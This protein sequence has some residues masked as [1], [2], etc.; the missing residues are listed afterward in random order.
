M[1]VSERH[2]SVPGWLSVKRGRLL[3]SAGSPSSP[4]GTAVLSCPPYAQLPR[5]ACELKASKDGPVSRRIVARGP[6]A[7]E[8]GNN[9]GRS[10][11]EARMRP[12]KSIRSCEKEK[13]PRE[14]LL[15]GGAERRAVGEKLEL[16]APGNPTMQRSL[17]FRRETRKG[18]SSSGERL[19]HYR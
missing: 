5:T 1:Q 4:P 11:T 7:L 2:Y 13:R 3:K 10:Q 8:D 15:A 12:R 17:S 14:C 16:S 18:I 19:Q 9:D 6:E